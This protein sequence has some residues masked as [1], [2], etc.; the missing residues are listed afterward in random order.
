MGRGRK[1]V[2]KGIGSCSVSLY[3]SVLKAINPDDCTSIYCFI[4]TPLPFRVE[5]TLHMLCSDC[6]HRQ[7]SRPHGPE[8]KLAP[9]LH[10]DFFFYF[11]LLHVAMIFSKFSIFVIVVVAYTHRVHTPET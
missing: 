2:D 11:E 8:R 5:D 9:P 1:A 7:C 6:E 10:C 3:S 4:K